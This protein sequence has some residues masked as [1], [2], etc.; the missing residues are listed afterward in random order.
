[1]AEAEP[2]V[3]A[4]SVPVPADLASALS[5]AE[6][7]ESV[8]LP[9]ALVPVLVDSHFDHSGRIHNM[10]LLYLRYIS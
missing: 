8:A 1:M 2:V 4:L 3:A 9:V 5:V 6:P 7:A 10:P